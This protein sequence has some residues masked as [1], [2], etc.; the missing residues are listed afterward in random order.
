MT[1]R[2]M[3]AFQS[4]LILENYDMSHVVSYLA[5]KEVFV[6]NQ[7]SDD[8]FFSIGFIF[9]VG[10]IPYNLGFCLDTLESP[11]NIYVEPDDQKY[12]FSVKELS[13]TKNEDIICFKLG[14][15]GVFYWDKSNEICIKI[16]ESDIDSVIS[17][18]EDML[19]NL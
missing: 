3:I 9:G 17:C 12:G 8:G 19:K 14:T 11:S 16:P 18:I 13:F 7:N 10:G 15:G 2:L 6:D 1:K 5:A 4:P